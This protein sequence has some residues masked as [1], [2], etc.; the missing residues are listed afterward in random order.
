[1]FSYKINENIKIEIGHGEHFFGDGYR[2]LLLSDNASNYPYIKMQ[3][4]IS[5]K[6]RYVN[7]YGKLT[8]I[9]ESMEKG[10]FSHSQKYFASHYLTWNATK[11]LKLSFFEAVV[12][13]TEDSLRKRGVEL[14]YLNPV[15]LYRPVEFALGSPDNVLMGINAS[16]TIGK[17]TVLYSQLLLDEFYLNEIR[18][19]FHIFYIQMTLP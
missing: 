19:D 14:Y 3:T 5:K 11:K 2:S 8:D 4:N 7:L 17:K 10:Y 6:I 12:W 9:S 15:I 18:V 1:M 16:M 13:E